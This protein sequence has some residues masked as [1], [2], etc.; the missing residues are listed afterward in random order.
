M[1]PQMGERR[2]SKSPE[3]VPALPTSPRPALG[4]RLRPQCAGKAW[5]WHHSP[6]Q[7]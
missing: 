6:L 4:H 2:R 1:S 3:C 7:L 5:Q